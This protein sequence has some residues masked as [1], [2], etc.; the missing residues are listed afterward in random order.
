MVVVKEKV[1]QNWS[2]LWGQGVADVIVVDLWQF[3][4]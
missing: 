3:G 4:Q 1:K 2:I